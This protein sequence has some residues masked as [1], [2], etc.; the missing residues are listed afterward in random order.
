M[1]YVP[2]GSPYTVPKAS[3][4]GGGS[5]HGESSFLHILLQDQPPFLLEWLAQLKVLNP[6]SLHP[7]HSL[8]CLCLQWHLT[9]PLA[10][11]L[12]QALL[13][14][15]VLTWLL[16]SPYQPSHLGSRQT[17]ASLI[18]SSCYHCCND[19]SSGWELQCQ[20][21][22]IMLLPQ[23]ST[24]VSHLCLF[25]A[26]TLSPLWANCWCCSTRDQLSGFTFSFH[27]LCFRNT[28]TL[29]VYNPN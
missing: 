29:V 10:E 19:Y 24:L 12:C 21:T 22:I 4:S 20:P 14:L 15:L 13:H 7:D 26:M 8:L 28:T 2:A 23:W 3:S 18:D 16:A 6:H 27:T 17:T 25:N 5:H 11:G 9:G 1:P